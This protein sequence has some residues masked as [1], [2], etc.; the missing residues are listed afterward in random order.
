MAENSTTTARVTWVD[1]AIFVGLETLGACA[2]VGNICLIIV[3]TRFKYLVRPSVQ[4]IEQTSSYE[5]LRNCLR[6]I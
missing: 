5:N 3:L 2:I 1:T 6:S 4:N